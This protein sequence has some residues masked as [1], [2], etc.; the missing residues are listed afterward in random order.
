MK[1]MSVAS[2]LFGVLCVAG[3]HTPVMAV[4]PEPVLL[5][6]EGAPDAVGTEEN[7]KPTIQIY[8][9]TENANGAA[10]VICPGGGYGILAYDHEGAQ[11]A[12]WLNT[13]GVTGVVL[14]Y[15]HSPKY[16]HPTPLGDV[17]RAIRHVRAN[18]A[19]LKLSP[20][21]IGV[22]GFSAGGHL[23]STVST[24]FDAGL[25]E[26]KDPIDRISCRPDFSVLCYPVIS[27]QAD[28]AHKG[29]GQNLLGDRAENA[30]L[31]NNLSNDTQVTEK[32]PPAFL[33]H[34]TEDTAV[35]VQNALAY[36][37]AL[38]KHKVP[39]EM[40][41]YQNGPHG[42]GLADGEPGAKNWRVE[43]A[44]WLRT[45]GFLFDGQ[46]AE[47]T[48]TVNLN[49]QPLRWGSI[50]LESDIPNAPTAWAMVSSGKFSIPAH[51][52]AAA[53]TCR[54][55]VRNMGSVEPRATIEDIQIVGPSG[56]VFEVKAGQKN[57]LAL[58]L[59]SE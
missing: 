30:E 59:K 14:K 29:S 11:V 54:V 1:L 19:D 27:I 17:Q 41:I 57:D 48:G 15:R 20:T 3:A 31:L 40:H 4:G 28:Y 10:I 46:R 43:L 55:V 36:Y 26:A 25:P 33:F 9:P 32:T 51:R 2:V 39:A 52:G 18:A 24:H 35:A 21:R 8:T 50:A 34:T 53:G 22:L 42:V 47:V 7:D 37:S 58:E 13:V 44:A 38:V 5:W 49:G 23:A 16:R 12:K 6:P 45:N 56:L